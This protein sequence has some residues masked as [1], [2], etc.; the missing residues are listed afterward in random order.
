MK[1]LTVFMGGVFLL[2]AASTSFGAL[3]PVLGNINRPLV[4]GSGDPPSLFG[5][6]GALTGK[7]DPT[8]LQYDYFTPATPGLPP[9][10]SEFSL[11]FEVAGNQDVNQLSLY[12]LADPTKELVVFTGGDS[13]TTTNVVRFAF[14]GSSWNL[15]SINLDTI[16]IVDTETFASTAF[17]FVLQ[18]TTGVSKFY[19]DD[20]LNNQPNGAPQMMV[21]NSIN[22]AEGYWFA[23][24]DLPYYGGSDQDF[25]D[26][27][28][29]A[30]SIEPVP[31]PGTMVLLG[32]G[33]IG[34]A[35]WGRKKFRK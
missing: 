19:G 2:V 25:N 24:E 30:Q 4:F 15:T 34:L 28:F 20:E 21:F 5:A 23:F 18:N 14:N 29:H 26:M 13:P 10:V 9:Y 17:G 3:I 22:P 12:S 32:T 8:Q 27:V 35:G 16:S 31:E 1:R 6:G 11:Q 7:A 33:L